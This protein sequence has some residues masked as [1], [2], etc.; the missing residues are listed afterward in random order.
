VNWRDEG[1]AFS[2]VNSSW[3]T[4]AWAQQVVEHPPGRFTMFWPG[5]NLKP[6][7]TGSNSDRGKHASPLFLA[8][9]RSGGGG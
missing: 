4:F 9:S 3:A 1:I 8:F 7:G 5:M 6:T 2:A